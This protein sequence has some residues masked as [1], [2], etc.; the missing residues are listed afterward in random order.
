[1][2]IDGAEVRLLDLQTGDGER[3]M[4][5]CRATPNGAIRVYEETEGPL[6]DALFGTSPRH[7]ETVV[8]KVHIAGLGWALGTFNA[9]DSPE[10]TVPYLRH[11]FSN[12]APFLSDLMDLMDTSGVG[13]SYVSISGS[14]ELYFRPSQA[15]ITVTTAL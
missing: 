11:F 10:T 8:P 9:C 15:E 3:R 14:G 5:A 13:Y 6:T 2:M 4:V 12:G 7:H 1:M